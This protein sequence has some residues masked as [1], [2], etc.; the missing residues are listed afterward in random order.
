MIDGNYFYGQEDILN[1]LLNTRSMISDLLTEGSDAED[2]VIKSV[3]DEDESCILNYYGADDT[4]MDPDWEPTDTEE[5]DNTTS[6]SRFFVR[7]DGRFSAAW[8]DPVEAGS[9]SNDHAAGAVRQ[10]RRSCG[11]LALIH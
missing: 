2:P 8:V 11:W 3:L 4:D 7:R 5:P 9:F 10:L 1:D 6:L